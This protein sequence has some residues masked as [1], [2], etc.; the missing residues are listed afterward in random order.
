MPYLIV[1]RA[2]GHFC[3]PCEDTARGRRISGG[4]LEYPREKRVAK[5]PSTAYVRGVGVI[6]LGSSGRAPLEVCR[7]DPFE[8]LVAYA[9]GE[10]NVGRELITLLDWGRDGRVP[11]QAA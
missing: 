7:L 6:H 11:V 9:V 4:L 3:D 2:F 10:D 5:Q 1:E 8:K